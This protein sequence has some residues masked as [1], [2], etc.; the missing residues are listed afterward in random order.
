MSI[1]E[2]ISVLSKTEVWLPIIIGLS[3]QWMKPIWILAVRILKHLPA[4]KSRAA[5]ATRKFLRHGI[6]NSLLKVKA[7]R[8]DQTAVNREI[9]KNY[10]F[11]ILFCTSTASWYIL[12]LLEKIDKPLTIL[13]AIPV[14]YFEIMW[15][16]KS[17]QVD[18]LLIHTRKL[19]QNARIQEKKIIQRKRIE[20]IIFQAGLKQYEQFTKDKIRVIF[21]DDSF[22]S[23]TWI[24]SYG[25]TNICMDFDYKSDPT[26]E[27]FGVCFYNIRQ[28]DPAYM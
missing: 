10:A 24:A 23:G 4:F 8:F 6:R 17:F 1:S 18:S 12:T 19:R 3:P 14:F 15:L 20:N 13:A 7:I 28:H 16:R 9:A 26:K 5:I 11:L 25:S 21:S 2:I 27:S 22:T